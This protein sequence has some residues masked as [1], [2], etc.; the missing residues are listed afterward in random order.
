MEK[1]K[2]IFANISSTE[3]AA[4]AGGGAFKGNQPPP[5]KTDFTA[6]LAPIKNEMKKIREENLNLAA[7]LKKTRE[8]LLAKLTPAEHNK[9]PPPVKIKPETLLQQNP[10]FVKAEAKAG[11]YLSELDSA[12]KKTH[13][14]LEKFKAELA[15]RLKKCEE[16]TVSMET[17]LQ[18][19]VEDMEIKTEELTAAWD[20]K[21]E[22][23]KDGT[24]AGAAAE[25]KRV[26][27]LTKSLKGR[28]EELEHD[29]QIVLK[30]KLLLLETKAQ[31]V[32][33]LSKKLEAFDGKS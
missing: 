25:Y 2:S 29:Y 17:Q 28:M 14:D 4:W 24:A 9:P 16:K 11:F 33:T 7:E 20:K 1:K 27:T 6:E 12:R 15:L 19:S 8:E 10:D 3:P 5:Q 21:F 31:L 30:N 18:T 32:E 22:A 23:F 26:V 13:A